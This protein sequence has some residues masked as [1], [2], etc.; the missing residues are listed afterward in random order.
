MQGSVRRYS[1]N[2]LSMMLTR[3]MRT[4]ILLVVDKA[5]QMHRKQ[6]RYTFILV[7]MC[8]MMIHYLLLGRTSE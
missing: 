5:L 8:V 4:K 7:I 2:H 1:L 3:I 6:A